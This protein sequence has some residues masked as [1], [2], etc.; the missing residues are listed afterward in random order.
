MT[1]CVMIAGVLALACGWASAQQIEAEEFVL[2]NGMKFIL[3]PRDD[4][5]L[6]VAAGWLAKVGSANEPA[7]MSGVTHFLE[8][9]MFKGSD[10]IGTTDAQAD[11]AIRQRLSAV[12]QELFDLIYEVQYPRMRA[13][14][15]EDPWDPAND[16]EAI[17]AVRARLTALQDEQK[18][19]TIGND[20]DKIYTAQGASGM[21]AQTFYDWTRYFITV[22]SNKLELWAWLESDRLHNPS[23]REFDAEKDVVV[24]E[25]R[26][27]YN[28]VPTGYLDEQFE[29]MFWMASPYNW[30]VIGWPTDLQAYTEEAT[31]AYFR[32]YYQPRNLVGVIVGDFDP[33]AA[34]QL[35]SSY[36]GRLEDPGEPIP[37]VN[38]VDLKRLG[39]FTFEGECDCQPKA[40]IAYQSVPYG[41]AD[42]AALDVVAE[43]LNGRTGRLYK[44]MIE[45]EGIAST[46]QAS[47]YALNHGGA[48][49]LEAQVKGDATPARLEAALRAELRRLR[50]E[51]VSERELQKVKNQTRADA[52]RALE[53]N[54]G[55]LQ[56]ILMT[57]ASGTWQDIN[58]YPDRVDAVTAQDITR[59][60]NTY[61]SSGEG[62]ARYTRKASA[63][64]APALTLAGALS[65][66]PEAMRGA[67]QG[68]VEAQ[69]AEM[70][71]AGLDDLP[72]L[73]ES[74]EQLEA[75]GAMAPEPMRPLL[76]YIKQELRAKIAEL[77]AQPDAE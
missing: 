15:F 12:R 56:E 75:Q 69:L 40:M 42:E 6:N 74:L 17:R 71:S 44:A 10:A 39:S 62:V 57:E 41:H 67:V 29:S 34:K 59:V 11:R 5:P 32:T 31:R 2:D 23:L 60:V 49:V 33:E 38:T 13:G 76:E 9:M 66:V 25:R 18:S 55:M 21:N 72:E 73:K 37:P 3:V 22:P 65:G 30:P 8:H 47:H 35:V 77:E 16:T 43:I 36:F 14:E 58:T 50:E 48:F 68:Q 46:A 61:L 52:V 28:S 45:G 70:A 63:G 64:G 20:F 26:Q 1:R 7:G 53:D 51:P 54:M 24:E 4:Q 19:T 27:R